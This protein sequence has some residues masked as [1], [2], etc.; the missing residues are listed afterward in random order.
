VLSYPAPAEGIDPLRATPRLLG[1]GA[2]AL[3]GAAALAWWLARPPGVPAGF[4]VGNGR[5]EAGELHVATKLPGR[6]AEVLADEGDEVQAGQLLARMDTASLDAQLAEAKAQV[7]AVRMRREAAQA[8]VAQRMSECTLAEKELERAEALH[9]RDFA[10]ER[11]VDI[12]RSRAETAHAACD[13]AQAQVADLE[14]AIE[15]AAAAVAR[16][17]TELADAA[18]VAPRA[19]RVQHRLAEPGEVLPAGGRVLTL[20]DL[21]DVYMTLF[22]PAAAAGR[23][24]VGAEARIVLD[25]LP[26]RPIPARVRF[27]SEEAQFTP[28]QVETSSER[29]KLS[30]RVKAQVLDG[31]DPVL[32]PGAP[33]VAWVRLDEGSPWPEQ[34]R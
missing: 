23:L 19:G 10:S 17:E 14:A 28:K 30:F 3:A 15:A 4:A 21:S 13:A 11:D 8:A 9:R 29:E 33:G 20:L 12:G 25:A 34:L 7:A 24:R 26:E 18:L 1:M 5:L 32:K 16:I 22:L 6:I 31:R 2:L 27:V